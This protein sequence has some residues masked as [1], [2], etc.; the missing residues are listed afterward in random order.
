MS[1]KLLRS[2][3][4]VGLAASAVVLGEFTDLAGASRGRMQRKRPRLVLAARVLQPATGI[5]P[6]DHVER[7]VVLRTRGRGKLRVLALT[8]S[9]THPSPLTDGAQ[10]LR[11]SLERCSTR[12]RPAAGGRSYRCRGKRSTLIGQ[13]QVLGSWRLKRI[14]LRR[15]R[16]AYLRLTLTLPSEAGNELQGQ[17]TGLVYRF[18][19]SAA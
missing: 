7:T 17:A 18:T 19:G 1:G 14:S 9:A 5:A 16:K 3:V 15:R 13:A 8:V 11:L 4:L 2:A 10:G 12:W 6:G